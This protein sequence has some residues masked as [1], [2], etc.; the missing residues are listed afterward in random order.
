[1]TPH[2]LRLYLDTSVIIMLGP[3]QDPVRREVTEQFF[4]FIHE[5]SDEYEL[6]ISKVTN[7]E[8]DETNSEE[9]RR[10]AAVFV[11]SFEH[12]DL[13]ENAEAENLAWIYTIDGVLSHAHMDDLRHVGYATVSRCDYVVTWNMK[14]LANPKTVDRVNRV[15]ALAKYSHNH[16]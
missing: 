6:V 2:K 3:D 1:M 8:L 5:N 10:W 16:A 15:N 11:E 12:T 13:P 14:H 9:K 7:E 4:R